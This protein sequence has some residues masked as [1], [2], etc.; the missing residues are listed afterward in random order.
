[1]VEVLEALRS[2]PMLLPLLSLRV[3]SICCDSGCCSTGRGLAGASGG[4]GGGLHR[5]K[6]PAAYRATYDSHV[7]GCSLTGEVS[8]MGQ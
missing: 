3:R 7:I 6:A 5:S 1:M 2:L 4:T 8:V